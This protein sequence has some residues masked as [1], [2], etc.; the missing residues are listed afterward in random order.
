MVKICGLHLRLNT[1]TFRNTDLNSHKYTSYRLS[2]EAFTGKQSSLFFL[3]TSILPTNELVFSFH[4]YM[5]FQNE[6]LFLE[7]WTA[8]SELQDWM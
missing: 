1:K 5:N 7:I 3:L 2:V 4:K 8:Y 6:L